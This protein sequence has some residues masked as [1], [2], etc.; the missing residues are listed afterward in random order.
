MG[1][2][3]EVLWCSAKDAIAAK[4]GFDDLAEK[5]AR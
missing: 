5:R 4:A 2:A 3:H 1:S